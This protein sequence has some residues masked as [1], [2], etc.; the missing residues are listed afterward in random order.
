MIKDLVARRSEG[1][2]EGLRL[3]RLMKSSFFAVF[4]F[5][6]ILS[7]SSGLQAEESKSY[8][9]ELFQ[10]TRLVYEDRFDGPLNTDFWEVR[11]SSTWQV[12][13]GVLTGSPAPKE[14][15]DQKIAAG[16]KAHA[17]LKPVIWLKQVPE[18]F[19]CTFRLKYGGEEYHPKFPLVDLGHHVHTLIF[20]KDKT[21]L[22]LKKNVETL[23]VKSP[24]L[25]LNQWVDVAIELKKGTLLVT[26]DGQKHRFQSPNIDMTGQAQIDF[27]GLDF[28]TCQIDD[29]KLWEGK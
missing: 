9:P 12:V 8:R 18:N 14:F 13:D 22:T 15:Q 10:Q 4:P 27:K 21:T 29:L 17:G 5:L 25:P 16:D 26:L 3:R 1:F 2:E 19:V 7:S 11:Q 20:N 24:L 28:G 23:E 6:L